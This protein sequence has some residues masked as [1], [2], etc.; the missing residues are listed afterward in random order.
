[1]VELS[2]YKGRYTKSA[3]GYAEARMLAAADMKQMY[4]DAQADGVVVKRKDED[5]GNEWWTETMW[6]SCTRTTGRSATCW[7]A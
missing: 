2:A 6:G 3:E 1:M 4:K 5:S 7:T